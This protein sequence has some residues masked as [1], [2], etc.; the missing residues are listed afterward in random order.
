MGALGLYASDVL[1]LR[2]LAGSGAGEL[3]LS[4]ILGVSAC[5]LY[6]SGGAR[7]VG[8]VV[9]PLSR[10]GGRA[11]HAAMVV[12]GLAI[13]A[14]HT[15]FAPILLVLEDR[16]LPSSYAW[17][18]TFEGAT[19]ETELALWAFQELSVLGL[20]AFGLAVVLLLVSVLVRRPLPRWILLLHPFVGVGISEGLL[21]RGL[22]AD[23][24]EAQIYL[25][26]TTAQVVFFSAC[27]LVLVARAARA[28]EPESVSGPG[29]AGGR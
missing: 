26:F 16:G 15:A 4:V 12:A 7:F 24:A 8:G 14:S 18:P 28:E 5:A 22:L 21:R 1:F 17:R 19:A 2:F 11:A 25:P 27:A 29:A 6:A 3:Q 13:A 9:D 10:W 23:V 20:L